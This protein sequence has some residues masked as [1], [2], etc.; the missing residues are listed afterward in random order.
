MENAMFPMVKLRV[1]QTEGV[2]SH[3][4]SKAMD[5]GGANTGKDR[6]Y[7]PFSG[8]VIRTRKNANGE[9]YLQSSG[10]VRLADGTEDYLTA[11]FIHD[12]KFNVV[13]GQK[14]VQGQYIY[15]EGGM[16]SGNAN[17]FANHLHLE[18]SR[19]HHKNQKANAYGVYCTPNQVS[20][21]S[22]L[23]LGND[24]EILDG[25]GH[26]WKRREALMNSKPPVS[27]STYLVQ[28]AD[29][30][31]GIAE[32]ELGAGT[33]CYALAAANG[34]TIADSIHPGQTISLD[35]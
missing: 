26:N 11:T 23:M 19:G 17:K 32:K 29:S 33:H 2:G 4:G 25:G 34:K 10:K 12:S 3:T 35:I 7:A 21:Y 22:A 5:L 28:A 15:D 13:E 1:T 18:I 8:T 24:V 9:L 6:V 27:G 20:L 31:W 30:W 14:V 16:G